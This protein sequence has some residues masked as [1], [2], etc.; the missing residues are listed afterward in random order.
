LKE[1]DGKRR[2]AILGDMLELGTSSYQ[3]HIEVG[4][5]AA[6]VVS[7]LLAFGKDA[8]GY[9]DGARAAGLTEAHFLGDDFGS[10]KE[11]ATHF[12]QG[13]DCVLLK[14]SRGMKT[15]RFLEAI[16]ESKKA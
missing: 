3:D 12:L 13:G 6:G 11:R 10:A 16:R 5:Q 2:V 4:K 1:L 14:G 7:V 9:V 15:E 8:A